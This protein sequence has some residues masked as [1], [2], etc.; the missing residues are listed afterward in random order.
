MQKGCQRQAF[1]IEEKIQFS[2][3]ALPASPRRSGQ[4]RGP[5]RAGHKRQRKKKQRISQGHSLQNPHLFMLFS[6]G[7]IFRTVLC[8][9]IYQPAAAAGRIRLFWRYRVFLLR[10]LL[11]A[12]GQGKGGF[13]PGGMM[14]GT[15]KTN[16]FRQSFCLDGN[17]FD[18]CR[19]KR[20]L[21]QS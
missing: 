21:K 1:C 5:Y 4:Q 19:A 12:C 14:T 3:R 13:C 20:R 6:A 10:G 2:Y 15:V 18:T 11:C 16:T 9:R 7:L 8:R 17:R